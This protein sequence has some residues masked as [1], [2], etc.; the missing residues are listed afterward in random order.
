MRILIAGY[1]KIGSRVG[2]DLAAMGHEVLGLKRDIN[3]IPDEIA[4]V[5]ANL[6]SP[7]PDGLLPDDLD[8]VIYILAAREFT[9]AAY[10]Q[11]YVD[12]VRNLCQALGDQLPGLQRF[13]FVSSSSVYAQNG[14]EWVDEDS[15]PNPVLFN[16]RTMLEA[17]DLVKT[18]PNGL[19][20]RFSGIYGPGRNKLI[21]QVRTGQIAP[22]DPVIYTNRIHVHDCGRV[23]VHLS[24]L[25]SEQPGHSVIL[26]SDHQPAAL[27]DI[28]HWLA[29][30]LGV[31]ESNRKTRPSNR[32]AGSKQL[33]NRRLLS[34]GF[35]FD[36]PDYKSGYLAILTQAG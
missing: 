4:P 18:L 8:Q 21:D 31:P 6:F 7:L 20:V 22:A 9:E 16:G 19:C 26:A 14:G 34:T 5:Q 10:R 32:R 17:E 24:Q 29:N 23:L 35:E 13:I 12:G 3:S 15:P 11:A 25:P 30:R 36:Y 33:D 27:H 2:F 1:G 28:Q